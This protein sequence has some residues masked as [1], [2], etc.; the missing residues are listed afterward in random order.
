M[1]SEMCIR[2]SDGVNLSQPQ[3]SVSSDHYVY[4][5]AIDDTADFNRV[6]AAISRAVLTS[7]GEL[8]AISRT[9]RDLESLFK[10]VTTE[11]TE[12]GEVVSNA[13]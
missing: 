12:A 8:Y 6:S 5:F 1:G 2:D 7:G 11:N 13:A 3:Q 10:Q 4:A 9:Q